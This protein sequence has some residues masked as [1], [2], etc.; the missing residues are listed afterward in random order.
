M[1]ASPATLLVPLGREPALELRHHAVHRGQ[2]L[3]RPG[4]QRAVEL[5]QRSRRRQRLR[6]LDQRPLELAAQVTLERAQPL[7]RHGLGVRQR[8]P[9]RLRLQ[10]E[11]A[12]YALHVHADHARALA[13]APERGYGEPGEVAHLAVRA[14]AHG[15]T[16]AL[17]QGV[18]VEPLAALEA[19]LGEA[20]LHGLAFH[21]A[22]EEAVEDELEHAPV[23]LRL[24]QRGCERLAEVLLDGPWHVP[25]RGERVEQLARADLEALLPQRVCELQQPRGEARRTRLGQAPVQGLAG[26]RPNRLARGFHQPRPASRRR[27]R[28]PRRGR[29][30]ASR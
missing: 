24:R 3:Q 25:Q 23:L 30:G 21:G 9:A 17:A 26:A 19:L 4:R 20:L 7:L 15:L 2:V 28:P 6:P 27:A 8:L 1:R 13:L 22:E 14:G 12:P 29:C 10:L 16:D 5:P 18:E 11:R